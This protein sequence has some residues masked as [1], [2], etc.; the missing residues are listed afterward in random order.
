MS[1]V[2]LC[3]GWLFLFSCF[4][5]YPVLVGQTK[6]RFLP[7]RAK[8]TK[9]SLNVKSSC[10]FIKKS[11]SLSFS[12]PLPPVPSP[13]SSKPWLPD[14]PARRLTN[15]YRCCCFKS[16]EGARYQRLRGR[17]GS[18]SRP[19]G[20]RSGTSRHRQAAAERPC[21]KECSA[22]DYIIIAKQQRGPGS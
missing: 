12:L 22:K 21:P 6:F 10:V 7:N 16:D 5:G 13:T 14:V 4:V 3:G 19:S 18:S 17:P 2:L 11:L 20:R 1:C 15:K 8:A 9:F